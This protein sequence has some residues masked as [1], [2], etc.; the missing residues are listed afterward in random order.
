MSRVAY[1]PIPLI[2]EPPAPPKNPRPPVSPIDDRT[3]EM[4]RAHEMMWMGF[5][6]KHPPPVNASNKELREYYAFVSSEVD[7]MMQARFSQKF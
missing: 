7:K 4:R 5:G 3:Y 2:I 1:S 6:H